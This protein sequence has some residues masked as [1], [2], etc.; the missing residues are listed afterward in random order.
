MTVDNP[1]GLRGIEFTEFCGTSLAQLDALT[2]PQMVNEL[3]THLTRAS[4]PAPS[5]ETIGA[6]KGC[7][8]VQG[9]AKLGHCGGC[10]T[11]CNTWEL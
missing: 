9:L 8:G 2:D 3:V 4:A 1:L 5:V 6:P 11:P 7:S 10:I